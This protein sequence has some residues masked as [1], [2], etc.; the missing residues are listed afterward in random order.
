MA[1]PSINDYLE[2]RTALPAN[3]SA[4]GAFVLV[5]SNLT[6]TM[7]LYRVPVGGGALE[8]ITDEAEP[9]LGRYLPVGRDVLV[10]V[11]SGG[12][13]RLQLHLVGD[14]GGSLRP[15]VVDPEFIHRAGGATRDGRSIAYS[16]NRRNGVDFDVYVRSLGDDGDERRVW[17]RGGWCS[18]AGFSPDGRWLAV[19]VLTERNGD[20]ELHLVDVE[21]GE[22]FEVAA[23]DEDA[24]V[25]APAWSADSSAFFFATDAGRDRPSIARFDMTSRTWEYALEIGWDCDAEVDRSG[26]VLV[27][28]VL[29]D[30][31]SKL[32]RFDPVSLAPLGE[33][34][35]PQPG[36]VPAYSLAP[37][38]SSIAYQLTAAGEP[39]DVWLHRFADGTTVRL[40]DSPK[41]VDP[42]T[43][44]TPELHRVPSFDGEEV[45]VFLY[46]PRDAGV[47]GDAAPV[48][49][50]IHGGP[51]GQF[52]PQFIPTIQY[53]VA[54][55]FAVVAPNVRG[56][57]G[58]GKRFHHLDDVRKRL[59]SVA[60]LGG[61]QDWLAGVDGIDASKCALLGGSYGGYMVLAG[62][63]FQPERWAAGVSIVGIS[64]LVTFLENTS[65]WRRA[66]REREYGS[67]ATDREFLESVSPLSRIDD[68]KAP[69]LLIHGAND[70]RVP[71]S[72]AEQVRDEL[73]ARGI[74][75]EL[76]AYL[77]EG[78]G[79]A[80]LANRLDAY[81]RVADF[82]E[83]VLA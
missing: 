32:L 7:Q 79:L 68:I 27:V 17:D 51:E 30:G 53:L 72:E 11:D 43:M 60:D 44:V 74:E 66:F 70:P 8:Q 3:F 36:V 29:E 67:L 77:D 46:R 13:E 34:P 40:T 26:A 9:V 75:S 6:G 69:L 81:P 20:N 62:L 28:H 52:V 10:S 55:G 35:L 18:A 19:V 78:H 56:S 42:S 24:Q 54:R 33:V 5:S 38:G 41:A 12:N 39:G 83:R 14:D 58:Y 82:L 2:I 80:K 50:Y 47:G 76:L 45:P 71:L 16:C 22:S 23:H 73:A 31:W 61:I 1:R 25:G 21:S 15:L 59:D 63:A 48:V 57:T 4:D 65:A 64:S 37:D 49:F